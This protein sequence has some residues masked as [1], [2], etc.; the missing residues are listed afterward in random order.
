MGLTGV[1]ATTAVGAITP[2]DQVMGLTGQ[3]ATITLGIVSPL[4]YKDDTITGSTSYTDVDITGSTTYTEDT[5][6]A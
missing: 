3:S 5:H 4:H 2:K 1:S 6:A